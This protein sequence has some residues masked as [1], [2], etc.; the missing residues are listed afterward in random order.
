MESSN[1][2]NVAMLVFLKAVNLLVL[3]QLTTRQWLCVTGA[4]RLCHNL[5]CHPVSVVSALLFF[6][7]ARKSIR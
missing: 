1:T 2:D 7:I 6:L 4:A 5:G 3:P